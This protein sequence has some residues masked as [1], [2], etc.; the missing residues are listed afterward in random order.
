MSDQQSMHISSAAHSREAVS[1]AEQTA[2]ADA[3]RDG[4]PAIRS[5]A[6]DELQAHARR[7][8]EQANLPEHNRL[9]ALPKLEELIFWIRA[10]M[11]RTGQS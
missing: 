5:D 1:L 10:G 9:M 6:V 2:W 4:R 11:A 8:I 3:H 7:V